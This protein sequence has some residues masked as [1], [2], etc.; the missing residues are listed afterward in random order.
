MSLRPF[1][2]GFLLTTVLATAL[3]VTGPLYAQGMANALAVGNFQHAGETTGQETAVSSDSA[4]NMEPVLL[5]YVNFPPHSFF[6]DGKAQGPYLLGSIEI[7]ER[8]GLTYKLVQLPVARL[9][10]E[11]QHGK[12]HVWT[13][14]SGHEGH[15]RGTIMDETPVGVLKLRIYGFGAPPPR[16]ENLRD[17]ALIVIGGYQYAGLLRRLPPADRG[18]TLIPAQNHIPAFELMALGRARYVMDYLESAEQAISKLGLKGV[19][20]TVVEDVP[21]HYYV[22]RAA[23]DPMRLLEIMKEGRKKLHAKRDRKP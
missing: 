21:I 1:G 9:Y 19:Q 2:L 10:N 8:A 3:A 15:D 20:A 6:K 13:G 17:T 7:L 16:Y 18:V 12:V 11:I 22:S 23:P 4:I 14:I 5:G